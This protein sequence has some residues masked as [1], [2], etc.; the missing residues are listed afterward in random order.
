[1]LRSTAAVVAGYLTIVF[2]MLVA[3]KTALAGQVLDDGSL[4]PVALTIGFFAAV[5]GGA[6]AALVG[7]HAPLIHAMALA[8]LGVALACLSLFLRP[9][10]PLGPEIASIV[11]PTAGVLLGGWL[12][13]RWRSARVAASRSLV[14]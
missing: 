3:V 1:M 5:A 4:S 13:G 10:G 8:M 11:V 12:S 9:P 6:V 14:E 7:K 2:V